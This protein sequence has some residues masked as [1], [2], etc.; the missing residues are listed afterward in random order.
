MD[1]VSGSRRIPF[2]E[3]E[4]RTAME[5]VK[6]RRGKGA[7]LSIGHPMFS[8]GGAGV[9]EAA[10][11]GMLFF[12]S[13]HQLKT[14]FLFLKLDAGRGLFGGQKAVFASYVASDLDADEWDVGVVFKMWGIA[15]T[16]IG[17]VYRGNGFK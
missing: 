9:I 16:S 13:P 2:T 14:A 8:E 12:F 5:A 4:V 11:D 6:V 10:Q 1:V 3:N 15:V 7:D 17:N